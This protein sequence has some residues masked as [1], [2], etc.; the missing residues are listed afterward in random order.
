MK[1]LTKVETFGAID[2][3]N[4]SL[5][6][7]CFE[8]HEAFLRVKD[9][10]RFLVVGRKGSGKTAIFK[11][12]ITHSGHNYFCFGHTFSDYPWHHHDLQA[13]IGIPD[14]DKFTHSW[15]YL[16]LLTASK[17]ILNFDQSLP[18]DQD[19][20]EVMLKI[21]KFVID[22]YG[23]R[24]PDVTQVFTP[25]KTLKLKPH[26]E[27]DWK[28]LKAGI[29]PE[30]VPMIELPAIVQE[31]NANLLRYV[32]HCLN[33]AHE[34]FICFDQLDLGFDPTAG[35]YRNRLIGLL[36]ASRDINLAA[37]QAGK[38]LFIAVFLRDDIYE[39][40]HFE[41]K[42]KLTENFL[43]LIEWDTPRTD[44]TLKTLMEKRFRVV[45]GG[46][47][48]WDEVFDE[49]K[50]MPGHQ[51]KYQHILDR[52]YLR[53]RD[54]IKF[55]NS[56]LKQYKAR[57]AA[58]PNVGDRFENIDLNNARTEYSNYLMNELDDEIHK[59][60]PHYQEL[61]EALRTIGV[62]QFTFE[63]FERQATSGG[64]KPEAARAVLQELYDFSLVGFYRPGGRGYGGSEYVFRYKEPR[65]RL[66]PAA[67]R[68]RIHPGL[69]DVLG[70][71]RFTVASGEGMIDVV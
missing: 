71:K 18:V 67:G 56:V 35:D 7:D 22:T 59:H 1:P 5:L 14:F 3:D 64:T 17:M 47:P 46:T 41:D 34:Y 27:L 50:E 52:T 26:F 60:L 43:S 68:F 9:G 39:T 10:S 2:A 70:L 49:T 25:S 65:T 53:P 33:P 8:D 69:I 28:I 21:E 16:I 66:D 30:S 19:S 11:R 38:N 55:T 54:I 20:M 36:L 51:T 13:R 57:K 23:T 24:D 6:L 58:D 15:K 32:I 63:E 37:R 45:L 44:K 42:N 31:L 61:V 40:L 12:L 48:S 29:S 4:D 62:W